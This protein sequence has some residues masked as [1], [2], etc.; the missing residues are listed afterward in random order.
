MPTEPTLGLYT[1]VL[2]RWFADWIV[3]RGRV[4]VPLL[5]FL[6]YISRLQCGKKKVVIYLSAPEYNAVEKE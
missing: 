4:L 3:V 2:W 1:S 6:Y 5:W